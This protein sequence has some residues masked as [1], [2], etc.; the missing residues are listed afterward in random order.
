M[1]T[2]QQPSSFKLNIVALTNSLKVSLAT[3]G[4]KCWARPTP[5]PS[6]LSSPSLKWKRSTPL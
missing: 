1:S 2:H 4:V 3:G 6:H 5:T